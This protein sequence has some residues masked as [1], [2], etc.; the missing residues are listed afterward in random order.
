MIRKPAGPVVAV[1]PRWSVD[2]SPVNDVEY[3]LH[4]I[5]LHS[6]SDSI[7]RARGRR[8]AI[9]RT[10]S[11][12]SSRRRFV[13]E[14]RG[15][16]FRIEDKGARAVKEEHDDRL[17]SRLIS[18][19]TPATVV[20][21]STQDELSIENHRTQVQIIRLCVP[22]LQLGDSNNNAERKEIARASES[23]QEGGDSDGESKD[24][25]GADGTRRQRR[26]ERHLF[27]Q[28]PSVD[29]PNP[30]RGPGGV[31]HELPCGRRI[32]HHAASI[33]SERSCPRLCR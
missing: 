10:A 20:V 17:C 4:L 15:I 5:S 1:V 18:A 25:L 26:Q 12:T 7:S 21:Y 30:T 22:S 8:G 14:I 23:R 33:H 31:F 2:Q 9:A 27:V 16:I 3:F 32:L 11:P 24:A 29:P 28:I 13:V 19:H 6:E